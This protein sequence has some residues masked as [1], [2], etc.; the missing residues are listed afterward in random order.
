MD[1]I[2]ALTKMPIVSGGIEKS[3]ICCF[4]IVISVTLTRMAF[5]GL[6]TA[7]SLV[8]PT[9]AADITRHPSILNSSRI[10]RLEPRSPGN[11]FDLLV[12]GTRLTR[13]PLLS[14]VLLASNISA[15]PHQSSPAYQLLPEANMVH[16]C[17]KSLGE[18]LNTSSCSS[19][20]SRIYVNNKVRRVAQRGRGIS[21]S[22]YVPLRWLSR[23]SSPTD[24]T[25]GRE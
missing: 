8:Y 19:A 14:S 16:Y 18:N 4:W 13:P 21:A 22:S 20:L 11:T 9:I 1:P 12:N 2:P 10:Q 5:L 25:I 3:Q 17:H 6:L 7:L 23:E 15:D 24:G